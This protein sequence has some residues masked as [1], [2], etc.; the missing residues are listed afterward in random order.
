LRPFE[1]AFF[2]EQGISWEFTGSNR[3]LWVNTADVVSKPSQK[4][5]IVP[6][7]GLGL[8]RVAVNVVATTKYGKRMRSTPIPCRARYF[9]PK[10]RQSEY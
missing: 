5:G 9:L 7:S 8:A 10:A 6:N 4:Q 2:D 3:N 1:P